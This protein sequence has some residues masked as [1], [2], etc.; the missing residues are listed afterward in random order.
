MQVGKVDASNRRR[1]GTTSKFHSGVGSRYVDGCFEGRKVCVGGPVAMLIT[2]RPSAPPHGNWHSAWPAT[3]PGCGGTAW[4]ACKCRR[5]RQRAPSGAAPPWPQCA[6]PPAPSRRRLQATPAPSPPP[7]AE[8]RG[9]AAG[10]GGGSGEGEGP[11]HR[12]AQ[13]GSSMLSA[14][15]PQGMWGEATAQECCYITNRP[16]DRQQQKLPDQRQ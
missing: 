11:S 8:K 10:R 12:T 2:R 5:A 4:T 6:C 7:V 3:H 9:W 15:R 14:P 13:H 1:E 16:V